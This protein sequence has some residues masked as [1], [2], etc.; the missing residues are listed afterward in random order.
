MFQY[1]N[2]FLSFQAD[3]AER[4]LGC[5]PLPEAE[6]TVTS[7]SLS[8]TENCLMETPDKV[9]SSDEA[10]VTIHDTNLKAKDKPNKNVVNKMYEVKFNQ[11]MGKKP[12]IKKENILLNGCDKSELEILD[13][14]SE[15]HNNSVDE[16]NYVFDVTELEQKPC[17]V[18]GCVTYGY[19]KIQI[20]D[21]VFFIQ[22]EGSDVD[23]TQ[24][25]IESLQKYMKQES[26]Q[27]NSISNGNNSDVRKRKHS[28]EI[29]L[30]VRDSKKYLNL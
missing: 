7:G 22:K 13:S 11:I 29:D 8:E 19:K 24:N 15:S 10:N 17:Y 4:Y 30:S 20:E 28:P 14:S 21:K 9:C 1:L 3:C 16:G 27:N 25:I 12:T 18:S 5:E 6:E 26:N 2:T 23:Q